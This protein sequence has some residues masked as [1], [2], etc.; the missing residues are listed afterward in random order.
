MKQNVKQNEGFLK[1]K[2]IEISA[3]RYGIDALGAMAQ[4]LFCSL[5]IGTI[6]KTLGQQLGLEFLVSVGQYA[7]DMSGAAMAVAIGYALKADP[8]V[9]FSLT[10]VGYSANALGGLPAAGLPLVG[11]DT[12]TK[13]PAG[14][15]LATPLNQGKG[16]TVGDYEFAANAYGLSA[17]TTLALNGH[18]D[19]NGDGKVSST[20]LL[21]VQKHILRMQEL[22]GVYLTAC[23]ANHDGRFTAT[24]L[25]VIQK[26]ILKLDELVQH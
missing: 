8:L 10:G 16:L 15:P 7:F 6:I 3:K 24:D 17:A 5:L 18:R 4:G 13:D 2:N 23:D 11:T 25:L 9:L 1:R 21:A 26:H 19:V 22:S 14:E 12:V 20:D